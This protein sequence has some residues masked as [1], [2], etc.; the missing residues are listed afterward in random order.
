ML[1]VL[2][3]RLEKKH[4]RPDFRNCDAKLGCLDQVVFRRIMA[5]I[6]MSIDVKIIFRLLR[7][8]LAHPIH[9]PWNFLLFQYK[10]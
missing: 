9:F 5:I 2:F 1:P 3:A 6:S 8:F 7:H 10:N 4:R